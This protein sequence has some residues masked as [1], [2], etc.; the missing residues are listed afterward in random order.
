MPVW[1]GNSLNWH[2]EKT[3]AK[4]CKLKAIKV[5]ELPAYSQQI[6]LLKIYR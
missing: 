6:M 4:H 1:E 5:C 3:I 2:L